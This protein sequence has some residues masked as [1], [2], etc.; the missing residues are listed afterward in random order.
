MFAGGIETS[1]VLWDEVPCLLAF[2]FLECLDLGPGVG[3]R[4]LPL[5][6]QAFCH[7]TPAPVQ[8]LK[9]QTPRLWR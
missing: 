9:I 5:L 3:V 8:G 6:G 7:S 1:R 2:D 4:V